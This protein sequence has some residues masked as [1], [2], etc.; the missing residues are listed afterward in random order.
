MRTFCHIMFNA[1]SLLP[2]PLAHLF[3]FLPNDSSTHFF[4]FVCVTRR[5]DFVLICLLLSSFLSSCS[6]WIPWLNLLPS[7]VWFALYLA[8]SSA[9]SLLI[10]KSTLSVFILTALHSRKSATI[11]DKHVWNR[12]TNSLGLHN[13][14]LSSGE[15]LIHCYKHKK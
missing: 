3:F 2:P 14:R 7:W 13:P 15:V 12:K 10:Q 4:S 11:Q 5:F 6:A 8:F 9:L 1:A